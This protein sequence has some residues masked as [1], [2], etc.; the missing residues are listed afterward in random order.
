MFTLEI[1]TDNAAFK[2][3]AAPDND[4]HDADATRQEVARILRHVADRLDNHETGG[5]CHDSNGNHVGE[6][7]LDTEEKD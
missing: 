4:R 1:K 7:E 3:D 2:D 6:W 5:L